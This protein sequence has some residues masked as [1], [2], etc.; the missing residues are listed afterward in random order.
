MGVPFEEIVVEERAGDAARLRL[1]I[2][3]C[4]Q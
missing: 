3:H 1:E 4:F 2:N